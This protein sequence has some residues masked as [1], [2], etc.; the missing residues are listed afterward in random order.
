MTILRCPTC[1]NSLEEIFPM[2]YRCANCP[3]V[4]FVM[5]QEEI[6]A[7]EEMI[8]KLSPKYQ[9][10]ARKMYQELVKKNYER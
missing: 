8:R 7:S 2:F 9:E 6:E 1:T 5:K 4:F 10:D 3:T